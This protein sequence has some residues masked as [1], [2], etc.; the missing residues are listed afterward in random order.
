MEHRAW[1]SRVSNISYTAEDWVALN[2]HSIY[3]SP[4]SKGLLLTWCLNLL[5]TWSR[6]KFFIKRLP[7]KMGSRMVVPMKCGVSLSH[8]PLSELQWPWLIQYWHISVIQR[9]RW[10]S[11]M[12]WFSP[13]LWHLQWSEKWSYGMPRSWKARLHTVL[14]AV[15]QRPSWNGAQ[16]CALWRKIHSL[17]QEIKKIHGQTPGS[18]KL[19]QPGSNPLLFWHKSD[20]HRE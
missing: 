11:K 19:L 14:T 8:L 7:T 12:S 17:E 16:L 15:C 5:Q 1:Q 18:Q 20:R 6:E 10:G 3:T 13:N 9:S 2:F 4:L